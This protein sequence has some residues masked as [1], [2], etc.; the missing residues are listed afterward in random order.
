M[1]NTNCK[2]CGKELSKRQTLYCSNAC[3]LKNKDN[4]ALRTKPKEKLDK[5]LM[6][7]CKLT[8]K[9]FNDYKNYSGVL[10]KH[11][12]SL[13]IEFTS[14]GDHF[15]IL[16]NPKGFKPRYNCKYCSWST[17]DVENKSG[18]ITVHL[19]DKHDL[20]PTDHIKAHPEESSIWTYTHSPELREHFLSKDDSLYIECKECGMKMGRMTITHLSKHGMTMD[21]YREK[22]GDDDML[23][24]KYKDFVVRHRSESF[25][26]KNPSFT[27]KAETEIKEYLESLG[28]A[29]ESGNRTLIKSGEIDLYLPELKIGIEYNGLYWHSEMS[30]K[31]MKDYHLN[32]TEMCE[33]QGVR[34]IHI[35]EDEW[36]GKRDIVKSK[37]KAI[38]HKQGSRIYARK[39][40]VEEITSQQKAMF[41]DKFHIQGNDISKY[42]YGLKHDGEIV[43][44]M[45]F[46]KPRV[47]LG[48][49]KTDEAIYELSRYASSHS[50]VGGASKLL[51]HAISK[52]NPVKIISYADRRWS[53]SI[54]ETLYTRLGFVKT[55]NSKVNYWYVKSYHKRYHRF[56][57]TK[58]RIVSELGGDPNKT[59]VQNMFDMGYDR[60]WDCGNIKYEM[61][62]VP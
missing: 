15:D 14:I 46:V 42:Y 7:V 28:V 20:L 26:P 17:T 34:L 6:A 62:L 58:G 5:T 3:K 2:E 23:S 24:Q 60:I 48:H 19:K 38:V 43:A 54:N 44:V 21:E 37:L 52:L 56:N 49:K 27:S 10:K 31:K 45:T 35:F 51:K 53:S 22:H 47:A 57:F 41:L 59:E 29:V 39:C 40:T 25:F 61:L 1:K 11:V 12:T 32:K 33:Q 55:D 18:C 8:G 30:G 50:V 4:I 36:E 16:S 13:N 9:T